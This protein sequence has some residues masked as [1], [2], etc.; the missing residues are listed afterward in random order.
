MRERD[1]FQVAYPDGAQ[2]ILVFMLSPLKVTSVNDFVKHTCV[3]EQA[4]I[5]L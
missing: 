2:L 1:P 5:E 4:I 3:S